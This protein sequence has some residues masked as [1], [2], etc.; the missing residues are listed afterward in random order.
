MTRDTS[1]GTGMTAEAGSRPLTWQTELCSLLV[2][3][4]QGI[5]GGECGPDALLL[6]TAFTAA[7]FSPAPVR[8]CGVAGVGGKGLPGG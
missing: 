7:G 2:W 8:S 3:A 1:P 4:R 5:C 6:T